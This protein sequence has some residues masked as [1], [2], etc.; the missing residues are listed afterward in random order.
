MILH[1]PVADSKPYPVVTGTPICGIHRE[2]VTRLQKLLLLSGR[3]ARLR[4][5]DQ[6]GYAAIRSEL[7]RLTD[8]FAD[9]DLFHRLWFEGPSRRLRSK[10]RACRADSARRRQA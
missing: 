7:A 1:T 3:A 9:Y 5:S 2:A 10:A 8:N 6:D 4:P